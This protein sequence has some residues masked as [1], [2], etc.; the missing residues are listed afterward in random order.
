M[1]IFLPWLGRASRH[2]ISTN[3]LPL[4]PDSSRD[5]SAPLR[6]ARHSTPSAARS[7]GRKRTGEVDPTGMWNANAWSAT[8]TVGPRALAGEAPNRLPKVSVRLLLGHR[9]RTETQDNRV[10]QSM[11]LGDF[12]QVRT[13][14]V[15]NREPP[16][17]YSIKA[18]SFDKHDGLHMCAQPERGQCIRVVRR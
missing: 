7:P 6:N 15:R 2:S 10:L 8:S 5:I 16:D 14:L 9:R 12:A 13:R 1:A 18:P 4:V 3:S 11:L 17:Q